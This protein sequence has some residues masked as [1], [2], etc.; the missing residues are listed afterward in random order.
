[1]LLNLENIYKT[2]DPPPPTFFHFFQSCK[3][4]SSSDQNTYRDFALH[5]LLCSFQK[6]K[7]QKQR[8]FILMYFKKKS[9][10]KIKKKIL[11]KNTKDVNF[12][13]KTKS[14]EKKS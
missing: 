6:K 11:T 2:Q 10:K 5:K 9:T 4:K 8:V 7:G 12:F 14:Y 1:M 13:T 3:L